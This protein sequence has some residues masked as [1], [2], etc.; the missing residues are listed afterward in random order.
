MYIYTYI[1]IYICRVLVPSFPK[2][3]LKETSKAPA[4]FEEAT[5]LWV[6]GL[7]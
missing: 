7:G 4:D 2:Q 6:Y 5:A 1:Y 3:A